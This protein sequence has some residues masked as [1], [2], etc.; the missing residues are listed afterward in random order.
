MPIQPCASDG[1]LIRLG[2]SL[3]F[4]LDI[5][6]G[7]L[8]ALGF[9]TPLELLPPS[10]HLCLA[11]EIHPRNDYRFFRGLVPVFVLFYELIE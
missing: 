7:A 9:I 10:L 2:V 5:S 11:I 1:S 4:C 3:S 8:C 6:P